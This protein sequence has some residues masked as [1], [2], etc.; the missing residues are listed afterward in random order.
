TPAASVPPDV[1]VV[2]LTAD[3]IAF[4]R[5]EL[6]VPAG[7]TFVIRFINAEGVDHNVSISDGD[8]TL[9]TGATVTGPDVIVDY[10]VPALDP[11]EYTFICD[12]HPIQAMTGTLTV[13]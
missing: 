8:T 7:E 4:D 13:R 12:F 2:E 1:H 3:N 11:G 6:E 10:L 5:L 9:F